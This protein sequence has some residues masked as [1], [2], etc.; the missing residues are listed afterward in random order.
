MFQYPDKDYNTESAKEL[1][2]FLIDLFNPTSVI[3]IGCGNGTWLKVFAEY[4]SVKEITGVDG[5][6]LKQAELLID[7]NDV[8][9]VDLNKSFQLNKKAD[10]LLCLEVAEHLEPLSAHDFIQSLCSHSDIIVFSAAIPN[11]GG[12]KHINERDPEYW[13]KKFAE[14][15]YICYD[16]FR[17]KFWLNERIKWWYRQNLFLYIQ[18]DKARSFPFTP[19]KNILT[20]VHP[21]LLKEK[22]DAINTY[23]GNEF[24]NSGVKPRFLQFIKACKKKFFNLN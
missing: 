3:D 20:L 14:N 7:K 6:D 5:E 10:L 21:G 13:R 8:V 12:F 4:S 22:E 9:Q 2:P 23:L 11:Q 17:E 24:L 1:I 19:I 15:G 18:N 16:I